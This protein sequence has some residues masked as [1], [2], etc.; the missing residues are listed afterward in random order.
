MISNARSNLVTE[1]EL[2]MVVYLPVSV[3]KE[4][5]CRSLKILYRKLLNDSEIHQT[6]TDLRSCLISERE[7]KPLLIKIEEAE[8]GLLEQN[9]EFNSWKI[10]KC[11]LYLTP[12]WFS[13]EVTGHICQTWHFANTSAARTTVLSS[14]SGLFT[15]FFGALLGVMT[16][17]LF[18][19]VLLLPYVETG[20]IRP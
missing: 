20:G 19:V 8:S 17:E 10:A 5:I 11:C 18:Q 7:G 13:S 2:L 6:E 12:I 4:W 16:E 15:L 14:T 3:F 9:S 1:L